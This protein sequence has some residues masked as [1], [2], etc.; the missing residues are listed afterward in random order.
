MRTV[1][2][3]HTCNLSTWETGQE[4][5]HNSELQNSQKY[6]VRMWR[7]EKKKRIGHQGTQV[8]RGSGDAAVAHTFYLQGD[9]K[10]QFPL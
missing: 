3:T 2:G 9:A 10:I 6:K 1:V 4:D 8:E 5:L 7:G